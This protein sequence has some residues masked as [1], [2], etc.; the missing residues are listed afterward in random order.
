MIAEIKLRAER[1][2]GEL[3]KELPTAPGTRTDI[4]SRHDVARLQTKEEI[5][6]EADITPKQAERFEAV[7]SIPTAVF[8]AEILEVKAKNMELTSAGMLR[9]VARDCEPLLPTYALLTCQLAPTR[10]EPHNHLAR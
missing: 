8:E 3:S 6:K 10:V 5:L 4:T 9:V 1:R 2:A 7:A